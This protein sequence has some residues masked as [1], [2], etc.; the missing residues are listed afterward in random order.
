MAKVERRTKETQIAVRLNVDGVGEFSCNLGIPFFEHMMNLLTK[1]ALFDIALTGK[2]DLEIDAHHTVEDAGIV[3]GQALK[4]ALGDKAGIE[5]YGEASV[6]MEET[7]ATCVLD[8]CN[9]PFLR[10]D[11]DVAKAKV[12]TFDTELAE[13]FFR[14]FAFNAGITMHLKVFYGSN[15]H[16]ILE[17]MFKSVGRA[18]RQASSRNA[19]V[20]GVLSTKGAL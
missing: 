11:A 6:P 19:R 13:E 18:L 5:R 1:H 3:L 2:G 12:G 8:I 7:L 15:L 17:A 9:R 14:A 16:H 10:F 4:Q 20:R